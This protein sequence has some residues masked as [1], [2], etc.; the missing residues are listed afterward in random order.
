MTAEEVEAQRQAAHEQVGEAGVPFVEA[1][2]KEIAKED[3]TEEAFEEGKLE[4]PDLAEEIDIE[5]SGG[6][7]EDGNPV[8]VLEEEDEPKEVR[9]V[10]ADKFKLKY[11]ENA[12]TLGVPGKAAKRSN[13][14]WLAQQ[15]A[16]VCLDDKHKIRMGDFVAVLEANGVDHSRWTNRNKGWEGR[17]R[18]TGRVALQKV[19]ANAGVLKLPDGET[20]EDGT[21]G[22]IEIVPPESFVERYKT[23]A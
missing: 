18:M 7:D 19:V 20:K 5:M 14:D 16:L 3:D 10:V 4:A 17:F 8:E 12:K 9:S 2:A 22:T 21:S 15:I 23:K 11:I 1:V 6:R 13:W